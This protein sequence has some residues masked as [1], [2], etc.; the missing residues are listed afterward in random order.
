MDGNVGC[1][2]AFFIEMISDRQGGSSAIGGSVVIVVII[3]DSK[4]INRIA[5]L[6]GDVVASTDRRGW[7]ARRL[8]ISPTLTT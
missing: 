4:C 7:G 5:C 1:G 8:C 6:D 2:E 3:F